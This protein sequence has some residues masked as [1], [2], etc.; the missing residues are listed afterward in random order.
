MERKPF[1]ESSSV[2]PSDRSRFLLVS[3]LVIDLDLGWRFSTR[4]AQIANEIVC[5]WV[6][7]KPFRNS[8]VA[9]FSGAVV[10]VNECDAVEG[11][12]QSLTFRQSRDILHRPHSNK[13]CARRSAN[14]RIEMICR[15]RCELAIAILGDVAGRFDPSDNV[16]LVS[17]S[18]F[19]DNAWR[20]RASFAQSDR[21]ATPATGAHS[22]SSGRLCIQQPLQSKRALAHFTSSKSSSCHVLSKKGCLGP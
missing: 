16:R 10:A 18:E 20:R 3:G 2:R 6:S 15:Y 4:N 21:F 12:T 19:G 7:A 22:V 9:T 17:R 5:R 14:L 13:Q 11:E 8:A 1:W